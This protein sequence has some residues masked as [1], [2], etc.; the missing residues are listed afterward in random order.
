M[1]TKEDLKKILVNYS[2][3]EETLGQ[4]VFAQHL[5]EVLAY[6]MTL[7]EDNKRLKEEKDE[8]SWML[9]GLRK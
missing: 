4:Y 1:K 3:T 6:I 2:E 8:L 7:E 9:D 5:R